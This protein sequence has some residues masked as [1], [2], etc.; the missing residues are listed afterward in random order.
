MASMATSCPFLASISFVW[1]ETV[2]EAVLSC[3]SLLSLHTKLSTSVMTLLN[4]SLYVLLDVMRQ[5]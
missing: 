4:V 5:I 1:I 3:T 2:V